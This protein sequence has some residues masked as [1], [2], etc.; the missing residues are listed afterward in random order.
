MIEKRYFD[1]RDKCNFFKA[2]G[3]CALCCYPLNK[4]PLHPEFYEKLAKETE[5][6]IRKW[7]RR[8]YK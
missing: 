2:T 4:A 7:I 8:H 3:Y 6:K 1:C 5:P